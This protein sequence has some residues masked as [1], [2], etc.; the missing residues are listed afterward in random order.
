MSE[1]FE[2]VGAGPISERELCKIKEAIC[3]QVEKVYDSCK[4]K[5]CIEDLEVHG[6]ERELI[7]HAIDASC[8]EVE[9][10]DVV[11]DVEPL[12][13]KKGF[14]T[15][16]VTFVFRVCVEL[17]FKHKAPVTRCGVAIFTKKVVLFGSQGRVK[18]FKSKFRRGRSDIQYTPFLE[19]D[20]RPNGKVEVAEPICLSARITEER[21]PSFLT[22]RDIEI[23]NSIL[24]IIQANV[25]AVNVNAS[26]NAD[27][28]IDI[29]QTNVANVGGG[30][31]EKKLVVTIG[32][33]SIIKLVRLVQVLVPSFG[34]CNPPVC[35]ESTAENPC[36][37]FDTIEFPREAFFPPQ[38]DEFEEEELGEREREE[39]GCG[40]CGGR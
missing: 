39:G 33:F 13:F 8:R 38:K 10:E 1:R 3:L 15:I 20:N 6:I 17:F 27:V 14:Y 24:A 28:D 11:I 16:T 9:V 40:G 26:G 2:H 12:K 5:D 23:I 18:I 36:E 30:R 21:E 31:T 25:A 32:L 7:K 29:D 35:I 19:Q 4:E 22:G 34:F 37:L